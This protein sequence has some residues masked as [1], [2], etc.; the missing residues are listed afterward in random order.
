MATV[1]VVVT[2]YSRAGETEMLAH[3]AAVGAVQG[4]ALIRLRRV[5]DRD[6]QGA[7]ARCPDA[8][9]SL[10]R[11]HRDYIEPRESDVAAADALIIA[12]PPD[13]DAG[14]AEWSP[15]LQLL[16]RLD[17]GGKLKGKVAAVVPNGPASTSFSAA[18]GA[19]GV[20]VVQAADITADREAAVALGRQVV[21]A[22]T[23]ADVPPARS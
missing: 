8:G 12:T 1:T 13:V 22:V 6:A 11:M 2:F 9:E 7:L 17:A 16:S 3:A 19:L 4:R 15:F 18:L 20:T 14:E 5:A 21:E 10:R 23:A